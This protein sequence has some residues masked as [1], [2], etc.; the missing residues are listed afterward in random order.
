MTTNYYAGSNFSLAGFE[1]ADFVRCMRDWNNN[2]TSTHYLV[3]GLF[4]VTEGGLEKI[5]DDNAKEGNVVFAITHNGKIVGSTGLYRIN[6][7][8]RHAEFR[9]LIGDNS[10]Y[11][12]GI[13][14]AVC[15]YLVSYAFDR[16]N[17][18]KV[19]LGVNE[20]NKGAVRS[21]EK[22]GF[23]LEGKLRD[24]LFRN[25]RYY[26]ILRMSILKDEYEKQKV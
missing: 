16:L 10:V 6:W 13:G 3:T 25:G 1:K 5:F 7:Q 19:W 14:T 12:M 9:I 8:S 26:D 17:M 23:K 21:Y 20:E 15:K 18:N 11:N 24:E 2:E 4:P 22:A